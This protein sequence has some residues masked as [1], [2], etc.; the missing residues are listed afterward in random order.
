ML[1]PFIVRP[2]LQAPADTAAIP[3]H[4]VLQILQPSLFPLGKPVIVSVAR[5]AAG[6]RRAL[7]CDG[8]LMTLAAD[9]LRQRR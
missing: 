5:G 2:H 7:C 4:P 9:R 3:L 8:Y 6:R 1:S